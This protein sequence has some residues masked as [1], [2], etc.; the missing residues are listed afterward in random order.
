M[1]PPNP[2]TNLEI[3]KYYQNE[4]R[5]NAIYPRDNLP[6]KRLKIT[7]FDSFGVEHIQKEI[8][9]VFKRSIDKFSIVTNIFRI[10][11]YDSEMCGYFCIGF[12]ASMLKDK[13]LTHFTNLFSPNDLN[14]Y[15]D[16]ILN[17]FL[18]NL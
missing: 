18:T 14:K 12:I 13:I 17:Y 10:Q 6:N 8:K 4:R 2:L 1:I 11:G 9:K 15:D 16:I 7:H 5:F 3:Q